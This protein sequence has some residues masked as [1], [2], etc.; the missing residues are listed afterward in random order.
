MV[1]SEGIA[2]NTFD[3]IVFLN[4]GKKCIKLKYKGEGKGNLYIVKKN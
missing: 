1:C 4:L 2:H 3:K